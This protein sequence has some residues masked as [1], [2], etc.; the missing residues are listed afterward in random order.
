M[1]L[2]LAAADRVSASVGAEQRLHESPEFHRRL[3]DDEYAWD[4]Q[5]LWLGVE[6][7]N[8][9]TLELLKK[10]VSCVGAPIRDS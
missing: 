1:T 9:G 3:R 7:G 4:G 5:T 6:I 2:K 10:S 8:I